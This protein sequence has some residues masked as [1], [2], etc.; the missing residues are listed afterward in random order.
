MKTVFLQCFLLYSGE[1]PRRARLSPPCLHRPRSLARLSLSHSLP[2]C[3][4]TSM[5]AAAPAGRC[6]GGRRRSQLPTGTSVF[7]RGSLSPFERRS[8]CVFG[9]GP[10]VFE[11]HSLC[12]FGRRSLYVREA[13]LLVYSGGA[14]SV[15]GRRPFLYRYSGPALRRVGTLSA[16]P[17]RPRGGGVR[18]RTVR[19]SSHRAPTLPGS[20]F[21]CFDCSCVSWAR[22]CTL[23]PSQHHRA[24]RL[25]SLAPTLVTIIV[26]YIL[27]RSW[28]VLCACAC[29]ASVV[30]TGRTL[31]ELLRASLA[32]D[33]GRAGLACCVHDISC[34]RPLYKHVL[35]IDTE[36]GAPVCVPTRPPPAHS[37]R[38]RR[39]L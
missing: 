18:G 5:H 26:E 25:G 11:R 36:R 20:S 19:L 29:L 39:H 8:L 21:S 7:G 9:R 10:S 37:S 22:A 23:R 27:L 14:P 34:R 13:P 17:V 32:S 2:A 28:C 4:C 33:H 3:G 12:V 38:Q 6:L 35:D 30:R 15:F 1:P 31:L 16:L 24:R